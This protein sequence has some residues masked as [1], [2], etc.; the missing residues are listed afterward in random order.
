MKTKIYGA[1]GLAKKA[2]VTLPGVFET[3]YRPDVIK[4]AVLAVQSTRRQPKGTKYHAGW[5]VAS[6]WGTGRGAARTPRTHGKRTHHSQRGALVNYTVGGRVAHP[7]RTE[8]KI[9]ERINKKERVLAIR[10]AIAAT[11]NKDLVIGRGHKADKFELLPLVFE[12]AIHD[13]ITKTKEAVELLTKIGLVTDI[14]RVK[15]GKKIRAGQGKGRGRKYRVPKG[16]LIVVDRD[17]DFCKAVRNLPGIEVVHIDYLN[18]EMLAPGTHAGRLT[19]WMEKTMD[20]IKDKYPVKKKVTPAA[21]KPATA[22]SK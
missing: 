1:I 20:I 14:D 3:S 6:S 16:P 8:K 7:P 11:A 17:S 2:R 22:A 4:R 21:K 5:V 9:V 12:D 15:A 19:V 10:S 13:K 18:A